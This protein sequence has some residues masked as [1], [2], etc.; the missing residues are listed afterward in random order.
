[1]QTKS[2]FAIAAG[3]VAA[4]VIAACVAVTRTYAWDPT[5]QYDDGSPITTNVTYVVY[6]ANGTNWTQ[7][8]TTSTTSVTLN[9]SGVVT[10]AVRAVVS[11]TESDN[12]VPLVDD[13]RKPGKPSNVRRN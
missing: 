1:M 2:I 8:A 13:A 12:S 11:G 10:V 9:V 3:L 6:Q 4:G 7:I 5:T